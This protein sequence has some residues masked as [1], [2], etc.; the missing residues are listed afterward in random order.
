[1][2][3]ALLT[4][5]RASNMTVK[6]EASDTERLRSIAIAK[7]RTPHYLMKEAI[8]TYLEKEEAEQR[9]IS[10]ALQSREHFRKTS[11]H[12]TQTEF[13]AWVSEVKKNPNT[14]LTACH[15]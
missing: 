10:A 13:S 12:I 3:P 5:P 7:K 14:P 6:L 8:H 11:L 9:F 4:K 15:K 2:S 1:M